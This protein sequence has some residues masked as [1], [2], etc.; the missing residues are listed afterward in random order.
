MGNE[1]TPS[2]DM[3]AE[4]GGKFLE[5]RGKVSNDIKH[6]TLSRYNF[7]ATI[8]ISGESGVKAVPATSK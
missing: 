7:L 5:T 8:A 1:G 4:R 2:L 6:D 3:S